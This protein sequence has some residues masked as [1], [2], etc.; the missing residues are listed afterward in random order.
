MHNI[1]KD[2]PDLRHADVVAL[3]VL[4]IGPEHIAVTTVSWAVAAALIIVVQLTVPNDTGL[5]PWS[6]MVTGLVS[7][8][9]VSCG[10]L[11]L[12]ASYALGGA[13]RE[14]ERSERLLSNILPSSIA[15]RLPDQ[16]IPACPTRKLTR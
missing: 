13:E 9:V 11:L 8:A 5:L 2:A 4:Y 3:T 15:A 7:N 6:L 1:L 14:Y 12:V 10:S 16:G